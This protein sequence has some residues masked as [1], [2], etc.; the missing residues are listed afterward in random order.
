VDLSAY[1]N[2]EQTLLTFVTARDEGGAV[3][4]EYLFESAYPWDANWLRYEVADVSGGTAIIIDG[5]ILGTRW[6]TNELDYRTN[7]A[8]LFYPSE[9]L[10]TFWAREGRARG[11]LAEAY[12]YY[13]DSPDHP[14]S[15]WNDW[16]PVDPIRDTWESPEWV[17]TVPPDGVPFVP[18]LGRHV[19]VVEVRDR[20][21]LISHCEFHIDVLE[22][23]REKKILL[24]DDDHA[25]Y[26][27]PAWGPF[28]ETQTELW[29]DILD[30]YNWERFYTARGGRSGYEEEV[31]PRL[32]G[33]ASTVIWLADDETVETP[34]SQ[35]L[36]VCTEQSSLLHSYVKA[37]GNLIIIGRDPI[38]ATAYW[39]DWKENRPGQP[40]PDRRQNFILLNFHPRYRVTQDDTLYN[41]MWDVFGIE[42]MR[43]P[44]PEI[45]FNTIW[46]CLTCGT[47]WEDTI[48]AVSP[49][50][51][52]D[53]EF[54]TAFYITDIRAASD[55]RSPL[56]VEPM[57]S[58]AYDTSGV[59]T[60]TEEYLIAVYVPGGEMRGHAAYIGFPAE[61]FDHDKM[62]L[63]IRK[64]LDK[65]GE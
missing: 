8:G 32:V 58:T 61:W 26:L 14:L 19:L 56:H 15:M 53:G 57:Y 6:S 21:E 28:D 54:E 39:S 59:T 12:R 20:N 11:N 34:V 45:P 47:A 44:V 7:I 42:Q 36:R 3:L 63:M 65:F 31:P 10:F 24:V 50:G 64:L 41:F 5:G 17:V 16:T 1:L 30:G 22:G 27:E 62:E 49:V 43:L 29:D 2:T 51:P 46:P 23:P 48:P 18:A 55:G 33:S 40:H 4:P 37:G 52:W 25:K 35:L 13:Y 38:R 60:P 9:V